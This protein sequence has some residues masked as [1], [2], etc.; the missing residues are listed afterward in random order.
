ML[1]VVKDRR[2]CVLGMPG[3]V[4]EGFLKEATPRIALSMD[5]RGTAEVLS[6]MPHNVQAYPISVTFEGYAFWVTFSHWNILEVFDP[7]LPLS[8]D[9]FIPPCPM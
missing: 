3:K 1:L 2:P 7:K 5:N 4:P 6:W 9:S 8:T